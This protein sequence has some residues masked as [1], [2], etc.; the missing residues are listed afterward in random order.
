MAW[1]GVGSSVHEGYAF[2][3]LGGHFGGSKPAKRIS[4]LRNG[5]L[6]T[7][8]SVSCVLE[9]SNGHR[10]SSVGIARSNNRIRQFNQL[11]ARRGSASSLPRRHQSVLCALESVS[12]RIRAVL[13]ISVNKGKITPLRILV[14]VVRNNSGRISVIL[15]VPLPSLS[16]EKR[17]QRSQR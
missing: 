2:I 11:A 8:I 12:R 13:R 15:R 10:T 6:A 17:L 5:E 7:R 14:Q 3:E 4:S 9:L 1:R 16:S